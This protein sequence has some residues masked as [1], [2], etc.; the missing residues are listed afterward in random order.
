MDGP[1]NFDPVQQTPV[2]QAV[3]RKKPDAILLDPTDAK[4]MVA[5][6]QQ[7]K[8]AGIPLMTSGNSVDSP[9]PFT[10][11]SANQSEGGKLAAEKLM[12]LLPDG[13]KIVV[14]GAKPGATATDQR[15]AGFE[16]AI[17]A[18]GKYELL[19]TQI[20]TSN[21][22][23]QASSLLAASL[24]A[25]PD[26]A[27]VFAVNVN[28]AKG[29]INQ[30]RLAKKGGKVKAVAF[31]AA[32]G[33]GAGDQAGH[34][35]GRRLAEPAQDRR[36]RRA[37]DAALPRRRAQHPEGTA[38]DPVRDRRAERRHARGQGGGVRRQ[39]L[40]DGAYGQGSARHGSGGRHRSRRRRAPRARRRGRHAR[41]PRRRG[42]RGGGA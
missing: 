9:V 16:D 12:E 22:P 14:V 21:D 26:L 41:R 2:L 42:R 24:R 19:P 38:A 28:T 35:A 34:P 15:Q 10:F 4:A 11:I 6:I 32:P 36:A 39:L 17:K 30:L 5:P 7:A 37:D 27:G 1:A 31:D 40:N 20:D 3:V 18:A 8:A 23:T 29:V 33:R 25:H 13:G